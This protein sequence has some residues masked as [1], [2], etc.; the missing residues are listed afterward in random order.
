MVMIRT[1]H[2]AVLALLLLPAPGS[3]IENAT[4]IEL[5]WAKLIPPVIPSEIMKSKSFLA[6]ATPFVSNGS[7]PPP[8]PPLTVDDQPWMSSRRLQP[9]ANG[10]VGVVAALNGKRVHIGGY[11]VPLDF[12]ATTI[13]EFLLV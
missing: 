4:P 6:G 9:G 10:H 13:K 11:V 3:A 5:S 8:A 2:A 7:E 1:F 12:D